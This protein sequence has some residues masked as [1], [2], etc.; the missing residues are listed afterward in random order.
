M[1]EIDPVTVAQTEWDAINA[2]Q[3]A[4]DVLAASLLPLNKAALFDAL[5]T[6]G[7]TAVVVNFDG[8][9]DSGQIENVEA[10]AGDQVVDLPRTDIDVLAACWDGSGTD[11]SAVP[12]ADAIESVAYD[13]LTGTHAGWENNDGAYGEFVFDA[14]TRTITL[15]HNERYTAVESYEHQW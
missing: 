2:Q 10:R 8:C 11:R 12:L 4:R 13:L 14:Q 1:P 6:A 7:V 15:D 3:M 5:D 9:G